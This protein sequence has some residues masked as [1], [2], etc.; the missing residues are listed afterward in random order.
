MPWPAI[1][2]GGEP[3]GL[4]HDGGGA[5]VYDNEETIT[6]SCADLVQDQIARAGIVWP[7]GRT[8]GEFLTPTH[9]EGVG[10]ARIRLTNAR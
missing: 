9:I 2:V 1:P 5:K 6:V 8:A 3:G 10:V 4:G 7:R